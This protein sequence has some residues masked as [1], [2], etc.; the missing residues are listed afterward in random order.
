[1]RNSE[2]HE[3]I[4]D[5]YAAAESVRLAREKDWRTTLSIRMVVVLCKMTGMALQTWGRNIEDWP[6]DIGLLMVPTNYYVGITGRSLIYALF[7]IDD[8]RH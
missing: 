4:L 3:A 8:F 1:M 6:S 2:V 7:L 5:S